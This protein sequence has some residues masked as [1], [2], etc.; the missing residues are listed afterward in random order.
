MATHP[1]NASQGEKKREKKGWHFCTGTTRQGAKNNVSTLLPL[2]PHSCGPQARL[3]EWEHKTCMSGLPVTA[4]SAASSAIR[5]HISSLQCKCPLYCAVKHQ[6]SLFLAQ[7]FL[8][9]RSQH[10]PTTGINNHPNL[11]A[12][13]AVQQSDNSSAIP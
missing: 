7:P 12:T 6:Q 13:R 11:K 5:N 8:T 2:T 1:V 3:G 10:I 4:I 9:V